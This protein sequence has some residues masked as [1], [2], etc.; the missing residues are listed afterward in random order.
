MAGD[1]QRQYV[2]YQPVNVM[3]GAASNADLFGHRVIQRGGVAQLP[4][5]LGW[6]Q[7]GAVNPQGEILVGSSNQMAARHIAAA[8]SWREPAAILFGPAGSG[9][10]LFARM[11]VAAGA[12]EVFDDL[13]LADQDQ[14]F[15]AWNRAQANGTKLLVTARTPAAL[16]SLTL[17]D[18]R[19][20]L[21]AVPTLVID[22]PDLCLAA[23]LIERLL[24]QRGYAPTPQMAAYAAERIVR[25][26]ATIHALVDAVDTRA[27]ADGR[28]L[29]IRLMRDAISDLDSM[30]G[31]A[32]AG[33]EQEDT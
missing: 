16:T 14:V 10:S 29:T 5:P 20:R 24:A 2:P 21:A 22:E 30:S 8:Q 23:A 32:P 28:M 27:M 7:S 3:E 25:T 13:S 31:A 11:F 4:L 1:R 15:H 6:G 19:T 26:Y 9:K 18:L 33:I 17:A 12:G